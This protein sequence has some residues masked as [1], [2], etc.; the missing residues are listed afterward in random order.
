MF[1]GPEIWVF[2][3]WSIPLVVSVIQAVR[4]P[5]AEDVIHR[6]VDA[7]C[8]F[9]SGKLGRLLRFAS[10]KKPQVSRTLIPCD[11]NNHPSALNRE[12]A[13]KPSMWSLRIPML[14]M[15]PPTK[16]NAHNHITE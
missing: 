10:Q 6:S 7:L 11:S 16:W 4:Q 14:H 8:G 15:H 13:I 9:V 3:M 5:I 2:L 1:D 12:K